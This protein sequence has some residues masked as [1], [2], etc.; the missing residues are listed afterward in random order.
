VG[1][2]GQQEWFRGEQWMVVQ[3]RRESEVGKN[4]DKRIV[5]VKSKILN[6]KGGKLRKRNKNYGQFNKSSG[7]TPLVSNSSIH[8][9]DW[10]L[11]SVPV[12]S[13][14]WYPGL[15]REGY[16]PSFHTALG[17]GQLEGSPPPPYPAF[18]GLMA[19]C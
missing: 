18:L 17:G 7:L 8:A 10:G 16:C 19:V 2:K 11:L 6:K 13:Q 4:R 9:Y 3:E 14:S 15:C 5:I 12:S 1:E